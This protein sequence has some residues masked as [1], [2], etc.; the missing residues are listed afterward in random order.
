[1][2]GWKWVGEKGKFFKRGSNW[3]LV[4]FIYL[5]YEILLVSVHYLIWLDNRDLGAILVMI[6]I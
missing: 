4:F 3:G 2:Y 6:G 5:V 1:M